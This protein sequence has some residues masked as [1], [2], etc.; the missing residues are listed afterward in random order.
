MLLEILNIS[1]LGEDEFN[2]DF[3][4]NVIREKFCC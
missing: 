1:W 4:E 2:R 3:I